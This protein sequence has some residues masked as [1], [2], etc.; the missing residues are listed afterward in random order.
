M[1]ASLGGLSPAFLSRLRPS[2]SATITSRGLVKSN[3]VSLGPRPRI[4]ICASPSRALTWPVVS[5]NRPS[6]ARIRH[7]SATFRARFESV[8]TFVLLDRQA[9][10][11]E[12]NTN[13]LALPGGSKKTNWRKPAERLYQLA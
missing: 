11:R 8:F 2:R 3:P 13:A 1:T 10:R 4:N 9:N 5:L 12:L 7:D 6:L